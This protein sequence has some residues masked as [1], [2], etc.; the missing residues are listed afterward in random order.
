[1]ISFKST[2]VI[3]ESSYCKDVYYPTDELS[4]KKEDN[5]EKN[6]SVVMKVLESIVSIYLIGVLIAIFD[7]LYKV[8]AKV[9]VNDE[10]LVQLAWKKE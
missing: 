6:N 4:C 5:M 3:F 7:V 1:M 2:G 9:S 8:R 10:L